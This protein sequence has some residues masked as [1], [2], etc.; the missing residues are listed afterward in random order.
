MH[1]QLLLHVNRTRTAIMKPNNCSTSASTIDTTVMSIVATA[2]ARLIRLNDRK[3]RTLSCSTLFSEFES[4]RSRRLS[5]TMSVS[6]SASM[7]DS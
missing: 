7:L 6:S 3:E 5:K 1:Q 2:D 4:P